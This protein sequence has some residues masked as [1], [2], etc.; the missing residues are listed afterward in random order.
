MATASPVGSQALVE[1]RRLGV[2]PATVR[3]IMAELEAAGYLHHPHTSAGRVPTDAGYRLYVESIP[4]N[5]P[6]SEADQ[7]LI[8]HQFGQVQFASEQWFRL[9]A[10]ALAGATHA[11]G[12]ATRAKPATSR[13]KRIHLLRSGERL[14]ALVLL[15]VEGPIKQALIALDEGVSDEALEAVARRLN[16]RLDGRSTRE[17]ER[18]VGRFRRETVQDRVQAEAGE[19]IAR[20]M[21]ELDSAPVE[22]VFSEGLLNV[23]E[24]PEFARSE[25]LRR[26]FAALQDRD[27][28]GRLVLDAVRRGD[29]H[30]LIG[31]ENRTAEMQDVSLVVAPYGQPGRAVG[32]VGVLGP[33]RMAYPQAISNV[34]YVSGLLNELVENLY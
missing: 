32:V 30:V 14:A 31:A 7:L 11:A 21:Q 12:L 27:Y 28:L 20:L 6:L 4:E 17:V 15:L 26:V 33:T 13:I 24:E 2:S 5:L 18:I 10:S 34:R 29:V 23:M 8:R 22:D 16:E 9:A 3:N 19:R 1:R 25:K